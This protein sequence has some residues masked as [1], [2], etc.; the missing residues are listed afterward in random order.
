M[1]ENNEKISSGL[2]ALKM[3]CMKR[4]FKS[5]KELLPG[6]YII[7]NFTVVDTLHGKRVRIDLNDL[8]YMY[9][10]ERFNNVLSQEKIDDLNQSSKIMVFSGKD[11]TDRD[12]LILDF[13]DPSYFTEM[14]DFV[15]E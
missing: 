12:R 7:R 8:T 3:A 15:L 14:L 11:S 5:F 10:P 2:L 1:S 13:R 4:T 9:L 6:E